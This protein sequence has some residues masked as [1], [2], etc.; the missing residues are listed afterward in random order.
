MRPILMRHT[1][2]FNESFKVWQNGNPYVHNPWH[3]HPECEIT[4]INKG[5]GVLFVGDKILNY[6][7]ND[8]IFIGPNLPHE[9]RSDFGDSNDLYSQSF[10]VHFKM[11]FLGETIFKLAETA[12]VGR[13]LEN[14]ASGLKIHCLQAIATVRTKLLILLNTHGMERINMLLSI[15]NDI[16]V[17]EK[18]ELLS[19]HGF[20]SSI[21]DDEDHR[22][23]TIYKYVMTNFKDQI[24]TERAAQEVFM[25][26]TSFCRYFKRSTNKSF[27]QYVNEIRVGY[28]CKLLLK[29]KYTIAQVA[30][31][32]GF[33]N[34]SNFNKQFK[35]IKR[36]TPRQFITQMLSKKK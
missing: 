20:V 13:M 29:E 26:E 27:I 17:S 6:S 14:S 33:E 31:N 36:L 28:A 15:L 12:P 32:S 34:I 18:V 23:T 22:M 30:F 25:T 11:D 10:A 24:F 9:W 19:S 3:Y 1:E 35:K 21:R 16:A 2:S 7:E 8:L 4:Y 5:K